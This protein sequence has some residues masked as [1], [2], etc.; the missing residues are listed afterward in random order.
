MARTTRRRVTEGAGPSAAARENL[1]RPKA[2][3]PVAEGLQRPTRAEP[4]KRSP[5]HFL[6]RFRVQFVADIVSEL[7]KV[8]WPSFNEVRYLTIVVAIVATVVG[9]L[10]GGMDLLF[11]WIIERLFFS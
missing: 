3:A 10:L 2:P 6:R 4:P 1:P 7:R 9:L 11:G 5:F 8:T